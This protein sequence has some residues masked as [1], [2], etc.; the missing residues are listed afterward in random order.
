MMK[1][2]LVAAAIVCAAVAGRADTWPWHVVNAGTYNGYKIDLVMTVNYLVDIDST[3]LANFNEMFLTDA[4]WK[5]VGATTWKDFYAVVDSGYTTY[6]VDGSAHGT[7]N[8]LNGP[9]SA[10]FLLCPDG[11]APGKDYIVTKT[12]YDA[13]LNQTFDF[14]NVETLSSGKFM[15]DSVPEPTSGLLLLLG[16]AGLALKR[17]QK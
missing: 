4:Y 1:K 7:V 10:T 11:I 6:V 3:A 2:L 5:Y 8:I 12:L 15:T 14:T 17:K 16:V 9:V 13:S